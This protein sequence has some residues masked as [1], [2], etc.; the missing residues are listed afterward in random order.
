[1]E[2]IRASGNGIFFCSGTKSAKIST[3]FEHSRHA[4]IIFSED[5][6]SEFEGKAESPKEK[7]RAS[8]GFHVSGIRFS[9]SCAAQALESIAS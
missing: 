6:F 9:A 8:F 2:K 1:M 7:N 3:F 4:T 5:S